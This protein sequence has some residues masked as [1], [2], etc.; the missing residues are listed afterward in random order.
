MLRYQESHFASTSEYINI[1]Q[2]RLSHTYAFVKQ[3]LESAR[4]RYLAQNTNVTK[5][6]VYSPGDRVW[7]LLPAYALK[8]GIH[9]NKFQH[10]WTG[11]YIVKYRKNE[12]IYC[13]YKE[14]SD[15]D[16]DSDLVN[17]AR[18]KPVRVHADQCE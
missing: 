18:L 2:R 9:K 1:V 6:P 10:P 17:I 5:L 7:L 4:D 3:Q 16:K 15:P 8:K 14:G 13:V 11:P 12:I